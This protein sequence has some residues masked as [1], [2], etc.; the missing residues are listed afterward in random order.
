[1]ECLKL[2]TVKRKRI[3][4]MKIK[5]F[6]ENCNESTLYLLDVDSHR[7]HEM[8]FKVYRS[9]SGIYEMWIDAAPRRSEDIMDILVIGGEY[10]VINDLYLYPLVLEDTLKMS[11]SVIYK[12]Y[13]LK[14]IEK[15]TGMG[16]EKVLT[17]LRLAPSV[18][19]PKIYV[20]RGGEVCP[21][22]N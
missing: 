2:H 19:A 4:G 22:R 12:S 21:W 1:M 18:F 8:N 11:D 6:V 10:A 3:D 20:L 5:E 15:F 16:G 14:R 17:S 7:G 13:N 9:L